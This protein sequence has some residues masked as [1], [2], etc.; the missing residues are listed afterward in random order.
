M[1]NECTWLWQQKR[2]FSDVT[3][4]LE[5]AEHAEYGASLLIKMCMKLCMRQELTWRPIAAASSVSSGLQ[6]LRSL[7]SSD[8]TLL[9]EG[10]RA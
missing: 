1:C 3:L 8:T 7:W 6:K 9:G 4:N 10:T 2:S 5:M